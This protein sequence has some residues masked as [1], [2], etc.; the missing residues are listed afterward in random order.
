MVRWC[1]E[2]VDLGVRHQILGESKAFRAQ[3]MFKHPL[4]FECARVHDTEVVI[5]SRVDNVKSDPVI[6][7]NG[8]PTEEPRVEQIVKRVSKSHRYL[9]M[10]WN[11]VVTD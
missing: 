5:A 8:L 10:K 2:L 7:L 9:R 3:Q 11:D 6:L 4:L 1:C